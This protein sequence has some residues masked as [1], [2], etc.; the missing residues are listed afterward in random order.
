MGASRVCGAHLFLSA[1]PPFLEL[2]ETLPA[3]KVHEEVAWTAPAASS[4]REEKPVNLMLAGVVCAGRNGSLHSSVSVAAPVVGPTRAHSLRGVKR[5]C[6]GH[7]CGPCTALA[8]A[9]NGQTAGLVLASSRLENGDRLANRLSQ[10]RPA[11]HAHTWEA[12]NQELCQPRRSDPQTRARLC[13]CV[14]MPSTSKEMSSFVTFPS[15]R[16]PTV[17]LWVPRLY[18]PPQLAQDGA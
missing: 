7:A 9:Y 8:R 15:R 11:H 6:T 12:R 5:A 4:R 13:L 1:S 3:S 16:S 14:C 17:S 18:Y 2:T 10:W